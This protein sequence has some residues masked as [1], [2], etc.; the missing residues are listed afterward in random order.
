M[1]KYR[2]GYGSI[3]QTGGRDKS[4]PPMKDVLGYILKETEW[5]WRQ[6]VPAPSEAMQSV[7]GLNR[8]KSI[9]KIYVQIG[10][11]GLANAASGSTIQA[12]EKSFVAGFKVDFM[13]IKGH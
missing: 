2:S 7:K 1:K 13:T 11:L 6:S 9:A 3:F 8:F 12:L 10:L 5:L 4:E